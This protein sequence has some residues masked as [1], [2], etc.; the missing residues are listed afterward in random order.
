MQIIFHCANEK[1]MLKAISLIMDNAAAVPAST[2]PEEFS[3]ILEEDK[4]IDTEMSTADLWTKMASEV[5]TWYDVRALREL[6]GLSVKRF[7]DYYAAGVVH[8]YKS[9]RV[10]SRLQN[11][12]KIKILNVV[13]SHIDSLT[14]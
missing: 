12:T 1:D 5:E 6:M 14:A 3:D 4:P 2:L 8:I 10:G 7:A 13:N 11:P 9:E